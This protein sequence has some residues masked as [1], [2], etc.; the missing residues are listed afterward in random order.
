M[1]NNHMNHVERWIEATFV[2]RLSLNV[3]QVAVGN[4]ISSAHRN[5]LKVPKTKPPI[6]NIMVPI[7]SSKR[8]RVVMMDED[9]ADCDMTRP[10]T[11]TTAGSLDKRPISMTET[12]QPTLRRSSR[13]KKQKIH[14]DYVYN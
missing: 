8:S 11:S 7:V 14:E 12:S 13:K 6:L 2:R 9:E 4:V 10:A 3:F 5:Q 1:K